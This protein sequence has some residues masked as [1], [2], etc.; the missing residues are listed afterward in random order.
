MSTK[1]F[2]FVYIEKHKLDDLWFIVDCHVYNVTSFAEEHPVGPRILLTVAGRDASNGFKSVGDSDSA[3]E[4]EKHCIGNFHPDDV[5][6]LKESLQGHNAAWPG[7]SSSLSL[8][9]SASAVSFGLCCNTV[10]ETLVE[11][12]AKGEPTALACS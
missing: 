7:S 9:A 8:S 3:K 6:Q 5:W 2:R 4:M 11:R 1:C 12:L 10:E